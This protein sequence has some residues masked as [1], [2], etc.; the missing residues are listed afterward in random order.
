MFQNSAQL[1]QYPR[2]VWHCFVKSYDF[3]YKNRD[4]HGSIPYKIN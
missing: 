1:P 2:A 3:N 4:N